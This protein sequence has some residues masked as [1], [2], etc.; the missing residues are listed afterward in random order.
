[1]YPRS[2]RGLPRTE[3]G[4][5]G[6]AMSSGLMRIPPRALMSWVMVAACKEM[7]KI[8]E[9]LAAFHRAAGTTRR[10]RGRGTPSWTSS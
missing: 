10:A 3:Q 9:D 4:P 7:W 2:R 8:V 1:M 6:V 5:Y